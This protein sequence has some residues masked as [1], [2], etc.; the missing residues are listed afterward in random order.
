[1]TQLRTRTLH[2]VLAGLLVPM[3]AALLITH[4]GGL[5]HGSGCMASPK[6]S[7]LPPPANSGATITGV[8]LTS[9]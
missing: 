1:M 7:C 4:L 3:A 5:T 2:E 6:P 9:L 8:D